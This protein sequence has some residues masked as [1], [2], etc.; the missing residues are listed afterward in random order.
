MEQSN[1][2]KPDKITKSDQL[3]KQIDIGNAQIIL[4]IMSN[5]SE[6]TFISN[7]NVSKKL[8]RKCS[9]WLTI[10]QL[11]TEEFF[12]KE[13]IKMFKSGQDPPRQSKKLRRVNG[14]ITKLK[15]SFQKRNR[16]IK[17]YWSGVS[18]VSALL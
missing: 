9:I 16:N 17:D 11:K 12:A 10:K 18:V 3:I 4:K 14:Q 8:G 15:L 6:N 7:H 5:I 13:A 2:I 1:E